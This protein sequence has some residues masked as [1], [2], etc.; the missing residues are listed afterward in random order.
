MP[1]GGAALLPGGDVR[2][3]E[4]SDH[5]ATVYQ[6]PGVGGGQPP[7]LLPGLPVGGGELPSLHG[8]AQA[9]G[10]GKAAQG[11]PAPLA[12]PDERSRHT[13]AVEERA[14]GSGDGGESRR[15]RDPNR[16]RAAV[17][18]LPVDQ[19][20]RNGGGLQYTDR[21]SSRDSEG[22]H[23][24][25]HA[26]G[27]SSATRSRKQQEAYDRSK[28]RVL[29]VRDQ[30]MVKIEPANVVTTQLRA[31]VTKW[32]GEGS[33]GVHRALKRDK[34][35]G[36][37]A[38]VCMTLLANGY[39]LR[40]ED[41]GKDIDDL[42]YW[43]DDRLQPG[44]LLI[45]SMPLGSHAEGEAPQAWRDYRRWL[46]VRLQA[47]ERK[48]M[49]DYIVKIFHNNAMLDDD[50]YPLE[51]YFRQNRHPGD[52]LTMEARK[53]IA[54]PVR[55]LLTDIIQPLTDR[56]VRE[57]EHKQRERDE[58]RRNDR[59]ARRVA[60]ERDST[61]ENQARRSTTSSAAEG[62]PSGAGLPQP[63]ANAGAVPRRGRQPKSEVTDVGKRSRDDQKKSG[64]L[65]ESQESS[66]GDHRRRST[67][68]R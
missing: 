28:V 11:G 4:R 57:D 10:G 52:C 54:A 51:R 26:D 56:L 8:L 12:G 58:R 41:W 3:V 33:E 18:G 43:M 24:R 27:G 40:Q 42:L 1:G 17:D 16:R 59:D 53:L 15:G 19:H 7:P 2:R 22:G 68:K 64:K 49:G 38:I 35:Q 25:A 21:D 30:H 45:F 61:D 29:L 50:G 66:D 47:A 60:R 44:G 48:P 32:E 39:Q 5:C 46:L 13:A 9:A 23:G 31:Y 36:F 62:A 67:R 34:K 55:H 37:H 20:R 65:S 6:A 63:A 14:H